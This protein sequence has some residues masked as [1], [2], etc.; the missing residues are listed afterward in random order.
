MALGH[1]RRSAEGDA[2]ASDQLGRRQR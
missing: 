1:P 2:R